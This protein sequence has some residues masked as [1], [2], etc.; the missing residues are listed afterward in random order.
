MV[1]LPRLFSPELST[2]IEH[3]GNH[4][5]S[6]IT[7]NYSGEYLNTGLHLISLLKK[8]YPACHWK[9]QV[10]SNQSRLDIYHLESRIGFIEQSMVHGK[11]SFDLEIQNENGILKYLDG[12]K[13]IYFDNNVSHVEILNTRNTYQMNVYDAI[14]KFGWENATKVAGLDAALPSIAN[15]LGLEFQAEKA[16]DSTDH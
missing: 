11:S 5:P 13:R 7:G 6:Y 3:L 9:S 15:L 1:N 4:Y 16:W 12:G 2:I 10:K 14:C 8:L